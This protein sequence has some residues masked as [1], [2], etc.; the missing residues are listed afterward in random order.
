MSVEIK[1]FKRIQILYLGRGVNKCWVYCGA[2]GLCAAIVSNNSTT[3]IFWKVLGQ[4]AVRFG[5]NTNR[6]L[7]VHVVFIGALTN[8]ACCIS[9]A[10][11]S[12]NTFIGAVRRLAV[13]LEDD[14]LVRGWVSS[15]GPTFQLLG[16]WR[17]IGLGRIS[18]FWRWGDGLRCPVPLLQCFL[19]VL[20]RSLLLVWFS[21]RVLV[22]GGHRLGALMFGLSS[23]LQLE[24]IDH[25]ID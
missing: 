25:A 23:T 6:A 17:L 12:V 2:S 10:V 24:A 5:S 4:F 15:G 19:E 7:R 8:P 9:A 3:N 21:Y 1:R 11:R 18:Y 16:V 22:I 14:D 13:E 20:L